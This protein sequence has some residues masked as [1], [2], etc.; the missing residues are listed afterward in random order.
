M[1]LKDLRKNDKPLKNYSKQPRYWPP[2]RR[3]TSKCWFFVVANS[4]ISTSIMS[5]KND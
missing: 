4:I 5:N 2:G 1:S 3:A